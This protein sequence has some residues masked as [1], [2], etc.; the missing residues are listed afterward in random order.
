MKNYT[1]IDV[2]ISSRIR[3][4]RNIADYPFMSKCDPTS[5]G[6]IIEKVRNAL[7]DGFKELDFSTIDE[8]KAGSYVEDHSVSRDFVK[9][10]LPHTLF[11]D[12]DNKVKIMVCEEDHVRLQTIT[13]GCSLEE[14]YK[15]ACAVDDILCEKLN[16]AY[17]DSL[18]Y[19]THCPTNLGCAMRASVMMFLPALTAQK[20]IKPLISQLS[21]LGL[22]IRGIYGEGSDALGC[23][24][25]ISNQESLGVTEESII[26]KLSGII[27]QITGLER[28]ARNE[29]FERYNDK[30]IDNV[31]RSMGVLKYSHMIESAEFMRCYSDVRM[32]I[33]LNIIKDIDYDT[34]DRA[35][36]EA[37][38]YTLMNHS[39]KQMNEHERDLARSRRIKELV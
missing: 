19:L 9:S 36:I 33:A 4:A 23:L 7:G 11:C 16:I 1:D 31:M 21:K 22:V 2:V 34:V 14:A 24:Y 25:Q 35:F 10:P 12:I 26:S 13:R 29:L 8:I 28:N 15:T 20:K 6:E 27:E 30:I 18:G 17:D 39:S 5:A 3:F 38:P 32:G 37:M